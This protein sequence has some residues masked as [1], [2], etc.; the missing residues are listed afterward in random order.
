MADAGKT[1]VEGVVDVVVDG[2][3]GVAV[4]VATLVERVSRLHGCQAKIAPKPTT[5]TAAAIPR[6]HGRDDA[7]WSGSVDAV[8]VVVSEGG[9]TGADCVG[10]TA[11]TAED[12]KPLWSASA[13][14]KS[15]HR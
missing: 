2:A 8:V 5:R 14:A 9:S 10:A 11:E 6:S 1:W 12:R 4:L 15:T 3:T 13:R 7:V